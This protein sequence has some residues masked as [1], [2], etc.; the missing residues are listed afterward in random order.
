MHLMHF[1]GTFGEGGNNSN[2]RNRHYQGYGTH[3][4]MRNTCVQAIFES[5]KDVCLNWPDEEERDFSS[6]QMKEKHGW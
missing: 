6:Q 3:E 5:M 2:S 4:N 1:L